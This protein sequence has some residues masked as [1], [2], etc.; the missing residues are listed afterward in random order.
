MRS[1]VGDIRHI[2]EAHEE[3]LAI[4]LQEWPLSRVTAAAPSRTH[5]EQSAG[6]PLGKRRGHI[7]QLD[8]DA[9]DACLTRP[10]Q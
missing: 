5:D 10:E 4:R 7:L 3:R 6:V 2:A 8:E 1:C 9:V